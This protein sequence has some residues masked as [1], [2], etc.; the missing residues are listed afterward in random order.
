MNLQERIESTTAAQS[1]VVKAIN[2]IAATLGIGSFLG[3]V[4][5]AV[6]VL[7]ALWLSVQLYGYIA[8]ELPMKLMRKKILQRELDRTRTQPADL[9]RVE[10]DE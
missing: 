2:Y 9:G 1:M 10:A 4:N 6:G 8:H 5:L 3:L 7:S